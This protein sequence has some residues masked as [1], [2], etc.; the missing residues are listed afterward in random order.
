MVSQPAGALGAVLL[1][2]LASGTDVSTAMYVGGLVL[3]LAAPLYL[4][5]WRKER[6]RSQPLDVPA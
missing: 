1:T 3:A 5:A 2:A 6:A 4:P